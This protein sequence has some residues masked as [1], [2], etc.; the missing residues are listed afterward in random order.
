MN[1]DVGI[2][3][4]PIE[5]Q[6][7]ILCYIPC[8]YRMNPRATCKEWYDIMNN[9]SC[10]V[11]DDD[12]L[13]YKYFRGDLVSIINNK[14]YISNIDLCTLISPMIG[15]KLSSDYN[16]FIKFIIRL[17]NN[18]EKDVSTILR[19]VMKCD[20]FSLIEFILRNANIISSPQS[21]S[22]GKSLY[23]YICRNRLSL[24]NLFEKY[25]NISADPFIYYY[26]HN[27]CIKFVEYVMKKEKIKPNKKRPDIYFKLENYISHLR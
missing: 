9:L 13:I 15:Y 5:I 23:K 19:V 24:Y 6:R 1:Q 25:K 10:N 21:K 26:D 4:L 11:V 14:D 17:R 27:M 3:Q 18:Y 16:N 8:K 22:C 12:D 2:T 20:R 7:E